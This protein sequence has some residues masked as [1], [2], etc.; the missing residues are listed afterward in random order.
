MSPPAAS[1]C[2]APTIH[3]TLFAAGQ[4]ADALLAAGQA[5]DAVR[6]SRWV[7]DAPGPRARPAATR[8]P[9]PP[10]S[11]SAAHW[12]PPASTSEALTVL[13]EAAGAQPAGARP[14]RPGR[15][16]RPWTSTP[17][18][19]WQPETPLRRCGSAKRSLAGRERLHGPADPATLAAALRLAGACL[20]DGKAKAAVGQYKRVLAAREQALG[21]DH[22]DT[23]AARASLAAGYDTAGQIGEALREHQQACAG[24]ERAPRPRPPRSPWPAARTWPAPTTPSG[25]SATPSPCCATASPAPSRPCPRATRS[26]AGCGRYWPASPPTCQPDERPGRESRDGLRLHHRRRRNGRLRAGRPAERGPR[27]AGSCCWR[28]AARELVPAM[29]VPDAWP[30][31]RRLGGGLGRRHHRPG[32]CRAAALP[33]RPGAGRV[34]RDQRDGPRARPPGGVRRLGGRRRGR[35]G[36]RGPAAVLQAVGGRRGP[37]PGAAR[38][39]RPGPGRPGP[40]N[41]PAPGRPSPSPRRCARSA[42]R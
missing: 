40:G 29:M 11:A 10:G 25:S 39:R 34:R 32:R 31:S 19:S 4:L 14:R 22:P 42:S 37:G 24:Y 26:P 15:A 9:S 18:R 6:C 2:S 20:A 21:P 13:R 41:Q 1:G 7:L 16:G 30:E 35:V 28:R 38:D 12:R 36:I 33:P 8:P 5:A 27:H 17:P 3:D 23:L